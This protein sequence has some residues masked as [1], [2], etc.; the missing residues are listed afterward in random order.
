MAAFELTTSVAAVWFFCRTLSDGS[1]IETRIGIVIAAFLIT[2]KGAVIGA[3]QCAGNTFVT[4]F[5]D[6]LPLL[7]SCIAVAIDSTAPFD[8]SIVIKITAHLISLI[9]I[10]T[11]F[12]ICSTSI[13]AIIAALTILAGHPT[14]TSLRRIPFQT[15]IGIGIDDA[16]TKGVLSDDTLAQSR[17]LAF[18][19]AYGNT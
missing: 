12:G 16:L 1:P 4:T 8:T 3:L 14:G 11:L 18:V 19:G 6:A 9:I 7:T 17:S 13:S 10:D 2:V 15:L 5:S